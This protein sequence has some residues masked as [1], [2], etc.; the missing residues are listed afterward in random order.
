MSLNVAVAALT[1]CSDSVLMPAQKP[2]NTITLQ[3]LNYCPVSGFTTRDTF[4]YN[5]SAKIT[6]VN[7]TTDFDRDGITDSVEQDQ[8]IVGQ[9]GISAT[10]SNTVN[11]SYSDL[12]IMKM[13]LTASAQNLLPNCA[14]PTA[15]I[16][17]DGLTDCEEA[18]LQT[19]QQKADTDGDGIPDGVEFRFGLNPKDSYDSF[20]SIMGDNMTN[21]EKLKSNIPTSIMAEPRIKIMGLNY[22]YSAAAATNPLPNCKD[23]TVSN[24][25]VVKASNGNKIM[26]YVV[27]DKVTSTSGTT[28]LTR[29]ARW[30]SV[31]VPQNIINHSSVIVNDGIHQQVVDGVT[32]PLVVVSPA[33]GSSS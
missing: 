13:G 17:N 11:P 20:Q 9:Y 26:V 27:E 29:E 23:I 21:L 32:I 12:V 15:D 14:N 5:A 8:N 19:D 2:V 18:Y 3:I 25:P 31:Y 1:G 24:I 4:A 22:T 33:G 16:D 6:G 28:I 10:L 7:W 30:L